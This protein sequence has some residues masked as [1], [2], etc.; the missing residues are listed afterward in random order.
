MRKHRKPSSLKLH[1]G[2]RTFL[3]EQLYFHSLVFKKYVHCTSFAWQF[4]SWLWTE[5]FNMKISW[6]ILKIWYEK[7]YCFK[8]VVYGSFTNSALNRRVKVIFLLHGI[9]YSYH[10]NTYCLIECN[11]RLFGN[12]CWNYTSNFQGDFAWINCK[13]WIMVFCY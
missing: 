2:L 10:L 5:V 11:Y 9:H 4:S 7:T 6:K 1:N 3:K 12:H 13:L 8:A